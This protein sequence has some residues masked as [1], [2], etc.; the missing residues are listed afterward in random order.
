MALHKENVFID[1]SGWSPKYFPP[2]VITYANGQLRKK[3]LFARIF[4]SS[5][6]R[7]GSRRRRK[8]ASARTSC[9]TS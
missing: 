8:S 4:R 7:R 6:L 2:Q 3:M 5:S 1:L 9:R